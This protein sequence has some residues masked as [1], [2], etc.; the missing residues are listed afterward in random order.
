MLWNWQHKHWPNFT[1]DNNK[2]EPFEL[3]FHH[4]SGIHIGTTSHLD[5]IQTREL[6]IALIEDE[7]VL[8]SE[9]EG[10]YLNR[11]SVQSSIRRAF[12]LTTERRAS[13]AENGMAEMMVDVYRHYNDPLT[14]DTFYAWHNMLMASR[15]DI[16]VGGYRTHTE[17]MQ[18]ISGVIY[19]PTVHFE[20]PPSHQVATH[21][22]GFI[23]WFNSSTDIAP[24]T[25]AGIAHLYFV[26]IHPFED[27][28]GRI[29]RAIVERVISQARQQPTMIALSRTIQ[30]N[31][32]A[33]Y[34]QLEANNKELE[35]TNWLVYF[36][37]TLLEAQSNTQDR[38]AFIIQKTKLFTRLSGQ[39]NERQLKVLNR[40]FN[41]GPAGFTGGLSAENYIAIAKTSRATA[42]R[43]LQ[44]LVEKQ[45]LVKTG[46]LK[47]TRYQLA[48]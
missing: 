22:Q 40:L 25:R 26:C 28:N 43:D 16:Q 41:A 13:P 37:Q 47:G 29:G 15:D 20:A 21:M 34:D 32:K 17:P 42:T 30:A 10:E 38:I 35:I 1:Y 6:T 23:D 27:G 48:L 2:L 4:K 5:D 45:A 3:D 9:I 19:K 8:S 14:H 39:L 44:D 18:V 12:D 7:A 36:A 33:Y 11:A 46:Q 24:L 31:R